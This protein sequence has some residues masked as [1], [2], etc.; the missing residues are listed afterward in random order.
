MITEEPPLEVAR[1][2]E[3]FVRIDPP[4]FAVIPTV[5]EPKRFRAPAFIWP[6]LS[7]F[8]LLK[9]LG[10]LLLMPVVKLGLAP[11]KFAEV[12][13]VRLSIVIDE[14]SSDGGR[15]IDDTT[16]VLKKAVVAVRDETPITPAAREAVEIVLALSVEKVPLLPTTVTLEIRLAL[17]LGVL[18]DAALMRP[19]VW[20][21][22]VK[23]LPELTIE[24]ELRVVNPPITPDKELVAVRL[25][26]KISLQSTIS[27]WSQ[28]IVEMA[29]KYAQSVIDERLAVVAIAIPL[30]SRVAPNPPP[31]VSRVLPSRVMLVVEM[32]EIV[33]SRANKVVADKVAADKLDADKLT[34]EI[35]PALTVPTVRLEILAR[36][37]KLSSCV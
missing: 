19:V 25:V 11:L 5:A 16:R 22:L 26:A 37:K 2:I 35:V 31:P 24:P 23:M 9:L 29:G 21:V 32:D 15:T 18:M 7:K 14:T 20:R 28:S 10:P 34:V 27:F 17:R 6:Q 12:L 13:T 4:A 3:L 1:L 30:R 8:V 33:A 36:K